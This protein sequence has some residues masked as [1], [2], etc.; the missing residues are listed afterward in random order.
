MSSA[1][2]SERIAQAVRHLF[3]RE[4]GKAG[5]RSELRSFSACQAVHIHIAENHVEHTADDLLCVRLHHSDLDSAIAGQK[6]RRLSLK[7]VQLSGSL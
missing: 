6:D 3:P 2:T 1:T 7:M 4:A 5:S